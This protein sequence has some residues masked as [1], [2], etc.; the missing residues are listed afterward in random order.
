MHISPVVLR[1][2]YELTW[3]LFEFQVWKYQGTNKLG[4]GALEWIH[5]DVQTAEGL[6]DTDIL[7]AGGRDGSLRYKK[8]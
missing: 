2:Y 1:W 6:T 5:I 8:L 7:L 4:D 3:L